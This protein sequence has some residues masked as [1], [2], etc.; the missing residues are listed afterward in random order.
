MNTA[1]SLPWYRYQEQF[2][3]VLEHD[4]SLA[5]LAQLVEHFRLNWEVLGSNPG[6][7]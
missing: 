1:F 4:N 3:F 7:V 5:S 2:T 6:Q